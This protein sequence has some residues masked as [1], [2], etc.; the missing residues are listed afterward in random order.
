LYQYFKK[1]FGT[2]P[3][4][5]LAAKRNFAASLAAY[6]LFSY[7][8]QVRESGAERLP[9]FP[10]F[11]VSLLPLRSAIARHAATAT[12]RRLDAARDPCIALLTSLSLYPALLVALS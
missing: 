5:L 1:T 8:L 3:E 12:T 2:S 7:V 10:T 9:L 4:R 11:L 6:S